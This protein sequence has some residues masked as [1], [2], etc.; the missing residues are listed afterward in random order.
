MGS[1]TDVNGI[2]VGNYEDRENITGCTVILAEKSVAASFDGRGGAPGTRETD[3]LNPE[4]LVDTVNAFYLSGGSALGL[5]GASGVSRYLE[6]HNIGFSTGVKIVPLVS[7]A[8][9]Y[10]LDIGKPSYPDIKA[11]YEACK[12]L[13]RMFNKNGNVGAGMGATVGKIRG[14]NFAMK[15]GL[16]TDSVKLGDI[17]V[18]ALA[19]VNA[20][21]DVY[22]FDEKIIAGALNNQ[23]DG[24]I[25]TNDFI[26]KGNIDNIPL[27]NTTIGVIAT[28]A[29]LS[30][31][32]LKR[33]LI[34]AH[35]GMAKRIRPVHTIYDGDMIFAISTG[36]I[37]FSNVLT[38]GVMA[39]MAFEKAI[40]NAVM[41]AESIEGI[42]S[43]RDIMQKEG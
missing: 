7:G 29:K 3:L 12:T 20:T 35:D 41:G 6:E 34:M 18:G 2:F 33:M 1:I 38:L 23:K 27:K 24:F 39:Q 30:K 32:Q 5:E 31:G 28:N 43:A 19:V 26:L 13:T 9:I 37:E 11:G 16:G 21:G 42:L 14:L 10:D 40:V 22:D 25:N 15:S 4:N 8:I 36:E 17:V